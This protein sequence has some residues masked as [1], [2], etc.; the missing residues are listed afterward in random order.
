MISKL[1]PNAVAFTG[2]HPNRLGGYNE[3][4]DLNIM[5][6]MELTRV[7]EQLIEKGNDT[8]ITGMSRG[9]GMWAAEVVLQ[10]KQYYDVKLI[11]ALPHEEQECRWP[12]TYQ[13]QYHEILSHVDQ[14]ELINPGG[15]EQWKTL[16]RNEWMV[17][18]A[19]VL[20]AVWSNP[21]S[22]TEKC[23]TYAKNVAHR[24]EIIQINP[25]LSKENLYRIYSTV[26]ER[27]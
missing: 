1:I 8:F 23:V 25:T 17:D 27:E 5:I 21:N 3:Q 13:R 14:V 16:K 24:P 9:V 2:H 26:K 6:K 7:V 12:I 4:G 19:H 15:Y 22:V 20:V 11:A 18:H 10:L